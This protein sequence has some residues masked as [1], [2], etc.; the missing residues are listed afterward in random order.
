MR[1]R[2]LGQRPPPRD[3]KL[4]RTLHLVPKPRRMACCCTIDD[5]KVMTTWQLG[6]GSFFYSTYVLFLHE[7]SPQ[8]NDEYFSK[9]CPPHAATHLGQLEAMVDRMVVGHIKLRHS[10]IP[11]YDWDGPTTDWI[12]SQRLNSVG[13]DY[14]SR[15]ILIKIT[16]SLVLFPLLSI[17]I[18]TDRTPKYEK[19]KCVDWKCWRRNNMMKRENCKCMRKLQMHIGYQS[20]DTWLSIWYLI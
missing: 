17:S 2:I 9:H 3:A 5:V 13:G 7:K 14:E 15:G 10:I 4:T 18:T 8:C 19:C 12:Q 1:S 11:K 16:I 6:E 20:T